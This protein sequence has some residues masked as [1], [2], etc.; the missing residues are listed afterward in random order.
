MSQISFFLVGWILN[1]VDRI[2]ALIAKYLLVDLRI[3]F[4]PSPFVEFSKSEAA[5]HTM[6]INQHTV[7]FD[8][9]F[10]DVYLRFCK[11]KLLSLLTMTLTDKW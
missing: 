9:E 4:F 8:A 10:S 2:L 3:L 6:R 5:I 7:K 11:E 1:L